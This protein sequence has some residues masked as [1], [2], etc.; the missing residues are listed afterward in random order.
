MAENSFIEK[1]KSCQTNISSSGGLLARLFS[2]ILVEE[3]GRL[4][5]T[6]GVNKR[7]KN[8]WFSVINHN[9]FWTAGRPDR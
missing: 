4:Q 8:D 3:K 7:R 5:Q 1:T 9:Y 2:R 6:R